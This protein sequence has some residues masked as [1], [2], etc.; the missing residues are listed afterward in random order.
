MK[1]QQGFTL[2]ELIVVIVIL[3]I[4]AATAMPRFAGL[5]TNARLASAQ[6]IMASVQS[7]TALTHAAWLVQGSGTAATVNMEGLAVDIVNQYPAAT[8]TGIQRAA[9]LVDGQGYTIA[10]AGP[11]TIT[12]NGVTTPAN[13]QVSYT[14]ATAGPPIVA[15]V[16][17]LTASSPAACS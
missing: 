7:A 9:G 16:I 13:C 11:I 14:A 2:I 3:G 10:G 12:P 15:P 5:E 8:A 6:G 4:L 17:I 1:N